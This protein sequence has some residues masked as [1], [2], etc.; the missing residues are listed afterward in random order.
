VGKAEKAEDLEPGKGETEWGERNL[1]PAGHYLLHPG[2][3]GDGGHSGRCL[4][5]AMIRPLATR[6]GNRVSIPDGAAHF[7]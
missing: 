4:G 6:F 1:D 5:P 3:R 7:L 2:D